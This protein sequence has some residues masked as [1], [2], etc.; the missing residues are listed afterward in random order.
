GTHHV[1]ETLA[2]LGDGGQDLLGGNPTGPWDLDVPEILHLEAQ[3]SNPRFEAGIPERRRP[4]VRPPHGLSEIERNAHDVDLAE[5]LGR[6]TR[7]R[8]RGGSP[9]VR[10]VRRLIMK[11]W[12]FVTI[13]VACAEP[14]LASLSTENSVIS[15]MVR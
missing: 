14:R 10:L 12:T 15:T 1:A 11:S 8:H 4:H 6:D 3:A 13:A 2:G 9:R 7:C 5:G